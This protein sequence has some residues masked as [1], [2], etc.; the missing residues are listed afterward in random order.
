MV[1]NALAA[2]KHAGLPKSRIF[3]MDDTECSPIDGVPD[4]REMMASPQ[5]AERWQWKQL[6]REEAVRTVATINYSSGKCCSEV[7]L[8]EQ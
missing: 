5:D 2:A 4:W 3:Q 1:K 8:Q 6:N 7:H